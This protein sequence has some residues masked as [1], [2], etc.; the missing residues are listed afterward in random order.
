MNLCFKLDYFIYMFFSF[1]FLVLVG[2]A[3]EKVEQM[4][5]NM[6]VRKIIK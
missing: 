2:G 3:G 1:I 4:K 6:G 5:L